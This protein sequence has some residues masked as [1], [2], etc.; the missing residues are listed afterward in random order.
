MT[1]RRGG[2]CSSSTFVLY[3]EAEREIQ[4]YVGTPC[5]KDGGLYYP[6]E[7]VNAGVAMLIGMLKNTQQIKKEL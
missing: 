6:A 2:S 7:K 4:K 5:H 3:T 1:C